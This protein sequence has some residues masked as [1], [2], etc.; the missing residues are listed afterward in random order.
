MKSM[1]NMGNMGVK[2]IKGMKGNMGNMTSKGNKGNKGNTYRQ[3]NLQAILR[4]WWS[5]GSC[6]DSSNIP[7]GQTIL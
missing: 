6:D 7:L 2:G 1:G 5:H 3:L 4:G